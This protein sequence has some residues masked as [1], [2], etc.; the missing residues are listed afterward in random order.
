MVRYAVSTD[1]LLVEDVHFAPIEAFA[2]SCLTVGAL[3]WGQIQIANAN[4]LAFEWDAER[5]E[6]MLR[7]CERM[8]VFYE[9]EATKLRRRADYFARSAAMWRIRAGDPPA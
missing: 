8:A 2:W 9:R 1:G 5:A 3:G 7:L 4:L 6:W